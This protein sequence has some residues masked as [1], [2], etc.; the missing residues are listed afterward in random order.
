VRIGDA[1]KLTW[2]ELADG[3]YPAFAPAT[4]SQLG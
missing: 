3:R 2:D 4:E 1:V